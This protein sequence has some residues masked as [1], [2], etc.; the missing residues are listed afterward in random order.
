VNVPSEVAALTSNAGE[1]D[2]ELVFRAQYGRIAR[3]IAS[4]VRDHAAAEELAVEVFLKWWRT[5]EAQGENA[6]GWLY[7]TAVRSALDEL[8]RQN[9]RARFERL[10][11]FGRKPPTPEE[12]RA[13]NEEQ[14][15]VRTVLSAMTARQAELLILRSQG[16]TYA[17]VAASLEINVASAGTLIGR[18][19]RAFR[20]EYIKRYG[21][22]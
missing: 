17:E 1:P 22:E 21:E 15:R 4:V 9:R 10:L 18:A 3:V 20:K 11:A 19:Q 12:V 2:L 6:Y 5:P 13:S 7:R 16:L 8:R 14:Q